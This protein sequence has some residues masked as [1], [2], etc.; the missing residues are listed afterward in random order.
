MRYPAC[1]CTIFQVPKA[2][3]EVE[4]RI[5]QMEE[6]MGMQTRGLKLQ[7]D[8]GIKTIQLYWTRIYTYTVLRCC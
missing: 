3:F 8:T 5:K 7:G 6:D 2:R 4:S 1:R